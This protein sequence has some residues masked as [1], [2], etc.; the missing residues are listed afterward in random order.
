MESNYSELEC[1]IVYDKGTG[2]IVHIHHTLVVPG[3]H[4]PSNEDID[5]DAMSHAS[6][7]AQRPPSELAI[8]SVHPAELSDLRRKRY[9]VDTS[10]GKLRVTS[11]DT[12]KERFSS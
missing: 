11:S 12:D 2:Q 5:G 1:R 10:T 7:L 3:A 8:L 9:A 4:M 6:R